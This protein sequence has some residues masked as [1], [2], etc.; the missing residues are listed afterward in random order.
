MLQ[1][2]SGN[3]LRSIPETTAVRSRRFIAYAS[4]FGK[5]APLHSRNI[6]FREIRSAP[7]PKQL[8]FVVGDLS[9]TLQPLQ[10]SLSNQ[11]AVAEL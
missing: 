2:V 4:G 9:P 8:P 10:L 5:S 11:G 6:D 7:F 1:V 3:P